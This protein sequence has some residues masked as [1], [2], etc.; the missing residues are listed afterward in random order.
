MYTTSSEG[1]KQHST[2]L[3]VHTLTKYRLCSPKY[4][5]HASSPSVCVPVNALGFQGYPREGYPDL[6]NTS[7]V[8]LLMEQLRMGL[9]RH[10]DTCVLLGWAHPTSQQT[11]QDATQLQ[12]WSQLRGRQAAAGS[13]VPLNKHKSVYGITSQEWRRVGKACLLTTYSEVP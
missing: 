12:G 6:A 3:A 1:G 4:H 8:L 9:L 7:E 11:P 5:Q 2:C 10:H 13:P